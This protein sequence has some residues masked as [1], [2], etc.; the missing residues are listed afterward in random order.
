MALGQSE[1]RHRAREAAPLL[2]SRRSR[3]RRV[4][5]HAARH[6]R[7]CPRQSGAGAGRVRRAPL[8]HRPHHPRRR[9]ARLPHDARLLGPAQA[10]Q[11]RAGVRLRGAGGRLDLRRHVVGDARGRRGARHVAGRTGDD[12]GRVHRGLYPLSAA[13]GQR[14]LRDRSRG[15]VG[16][17][18]SLQAQ[19]HA[20]APARGA[21]VAGAAAYRL[22]HGRPPRR[23]HR[24]GRHRAARRAQ[25]PRRAR[26]A[27]VGGGGQAQRRDVRRHGDRHQRRRHWRA[28]AVDQTSRASAWLAFGNNAGSA[29]DFRVTV[30]AT[31][32]TFTGQPTPAVAGV[33]ISPAV[34]VV[35]Q[36]ALGNTLTS[37]NG[38]VTVVLASNP[39]GDTLSGT[40]AVAAQN[41][42]ATFAD[43]S[44]TRVGAGYTLQASATL[45]GTTLTA[46]SNSFTVSPAVAKR[47]VFTGQPG[48]TPAGAAIPAIQVTARDSFGNTATGF[49]GNVTLAIGTNPGGGTLS[50]T[51][52]Q[53]AVGGV[54]SFSGLTINKAGT[55][56]TLTAAA[57]GLA[58]GTS[59]PFNITAAAAGQLA[60][61]TP[62]SSAA[63]S[64]VPIA[65]QPV[66]RTED[67]NGNPVSRS[68]TPVTAA[69]ASGGPALSGVNPVATDAGGRAAFTNLTI[70]GVAGPRTL[71][72]TAAQLA[73]LTSG[74]VTVIAGA[75]T[76]VAV[77]AGNNQTV[78][79]GSAVPIPPSVIVKDASGNPVPGVGVTFAVAPGSGSLTGA[80]QTTDAGGIATVGSWT[81]GTTAGANSLTATSA[82]LAGSP[83]TFT[84][85][86]TAG[87]AGSI[88]VDAGD[89]QSASVN[90]AM[91][92]PPAVI[93]KDAHGNPVQGV[94]VTF[95]VGLG[96]GSITGASQTTNA[97]G[98]A[99]VGSWTL[100]TAAGQNTLTAT[101][102]GVNGSPITF[103]ASGTAGA[104]SAARSL[105]VA[106]PGTITAS[107]GASAATITVT[108][109]DEFGNPVSGVTVTLG[110]TG[111]GN[112]LAQPAGPT[113]PNGQ[114]TGTLSSTKAETKTISA[115]LNG[116]TQVGAT[117]SVSVTPAAA[118]SIA[119]S[120]GDGQT[121]T[122]GTAVLVPPA[123]IVRDAFANPV[124][125]VSVT[126]AAGTGGG[127]ITGASQTTN[128]SGVAA[129]TSW[130]LG[131]A[132][133]PNTLTATSGTL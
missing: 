99:A 50:G 43:L 8:P 11:F 30:A 102:P 47:L 40:K 113:G 120:T 51:P 115:T 79:A 26:Y 85:T 68:G 77:N 97:S 106:V 44:V 81:L 14:K 39:G 124:A 121:A 105:V 34:Q 133:G 117:A 64:G 118:A 71:S 49:A 46:T 59:A 91:A 52:T 12:A 37:F 25:R 63:R 35:A 42:V 76:Q 100:G 114:V 128:A 7:E 75:A 132:A 96:S 54:A 24:S 1:R 48:N 16:A 22:G 84:A 112:A 116:V 78:A 129:V 93:V 73:V 60:F 107:T 72:F 103:T 57:T 109:N 126:F 119:V 45:S 62:P 2:Q 13:P 110:A 10:Q 95:A 111:T 67:V 5:R 3:Q 21:R 94:S 65:Q 28:R 98:I 108:A 29:T 18:R 74:P 56:Y 130:T 66:L 15:R 123:V 82:G 55:G 86:G 31:Q 131:T 83:V 61:A 101:A 69:I 27:A 125:G 90:T 87:T 19:R 80:T 38:T 88:A 92:T 41:G 20:A 4:S 104:P 23:Q 122:V 9:A 17:S 36:D 70:T 33:A 53:A 6:R 89:N 58:V 32:L 127:S